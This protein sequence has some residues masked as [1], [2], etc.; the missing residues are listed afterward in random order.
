MPRTRYVG[1]ADLIPFRNLPGAAIRA[2][3][4][5]GYGPADFRADVLAGMVVGV[6]ALPLSMALA[7]AV[8]VP[9][10]HGL[11]TAIVAG[12]VV[13]LLGGSRTQVTGPTAAFVVILAPIY[14]KF[15]LA[16]LLVAG[17]MAGVICVCLALGRMG[18]L[19][20]FIPHPV[21]T[22]FTAG[23]AVVIATIQVKD[24]LGLHVEHMPEHYL[25]RVGALAAALPTVSPPS[26]FIGALTLLLLLTVPKLTRRIPAPLAALAI[27]TI[28]AAALHASIG[29]RFTVATIG[30]RF[31]LEATPPLPVLPWN[32]AGPAGGEFHLDFATIRALLPAAFAIAML[33]A[34]ESLLAAVVADGMAGTKHDPDAELFALG[35]GNMICPF[36]GGIA[37][38]GAIA[39]T[40]TNIRSG[41][42]SPIAATVHALVILASVLVLAPVLRHIPMTSLAALLI[43]VAWNMSEVKH[44]VHVVR[45]A[46]RSDV[47]VLLTCFGLTVVFD[48]VIG[49]SVGIVLAALLFMRRMADVTQARV[50]ERDAVR[51][52]EPVPEG[53]VVYDIAGPLFFGAA[54]KAMSALGSIANRA[55]VVILELD[56]VSVM[57]ATGLVALESALRQIE[58]SGAVAILCSLQAQPAALLAKAG[59]REKPGVLLIA[60]DVPTAIRAARLE[61]EARSS[62]V[63]VVVPG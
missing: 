22:G 57:D 25:E 39:R 9:P 5:E 40:A 41:A 14:V 45:V 6:V 50:L 55:R 46:P 30:S 18:K 44:F 59:I 21:T 8:G 36:F 58:K 16:G 60:P 43:L 51:T 52:K 15:G 29:D 61:L 47:A 42:R 48:M 34:I 13:S 38:T 2:V 24:F 1:S 31:T 35:V 37:C 49:V 20:R 53:V 62:G 11:Y 10:Q 33:G 7:I 3:L 26:L 27:G 32:L 19:L 54:E 28:A 63:P 23:I 56:D 17:W 12:I 4:R